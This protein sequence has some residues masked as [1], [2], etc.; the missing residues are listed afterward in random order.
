M[1]WIIALDHQRQYSAG[2][3]PCLIPSGPFQQRVAVCQRRQPELASLGNQVPMEMLRQYLGIRT[4]LVHRSWISRDAEREQARLVPD[5]D[6]L[7]EG[8][9]GKLAIA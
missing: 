9:R 3:S 8:A 2:H 4:P 7:H 5:F 6:R 1:R